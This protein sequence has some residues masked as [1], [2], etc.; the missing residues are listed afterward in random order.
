M[1][2]RTE[3]SLLARRVPM[4]LSIA[5]GVVALF[6]SGVGLYG[7][8][9]YL[10]TS[11]TKEIGIRM[12]LGSGP[13]GIVQLILNEGMLLIVGGLVAGLIGTMALSGTLQNQ[14]FGVRPN[15]PSILFLM[16][17]TL[18]LIGF[19]ACALPAYRATKV[20]PT[21]AL[22]SRIPHPLRR[23]WARY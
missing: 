7:V 18:G 17:A 5:F 10:V 13:R 4:Q 14:L 9:A 20:D 8:L 11:R 19:L 3:Q 2:D 12:A 22:A 1:T 23:Q 16:M 15:A 21:I 6:L